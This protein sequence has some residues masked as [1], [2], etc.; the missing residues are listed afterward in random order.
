MAATA[1]IINQ[2]RV[3]R[4]NLHELIFKDDADAYD[5]LTIACAWAIFWALFFPIGKPLLWKATYGK[6]WLRKGITKEVQRAG[7]WKAMNEAMGTD[8]TN[9][10]ELIAHMMWN[11][12]DFQIGTF[13]HMIGGVLCIPSLLGIGDSNWSSSLAVLGILSEVGWEI[14]HMV[15]DVFYPRIRYG[16]E[17]VPMIVIIGSLIHHSLATGLGI[18]LILRYRQWQILHALSFDLQFGPTLVAPL[19][20]YGKLLDVAN[21]SELCRFKIINLLKVI[22]VG[23]TRGINFVYLVVHA[24]I[25]WYNDKAWVF[26]I[27]GSPL[28]LAF[29]YFCCYFYVLGTVKTYLKFRNAT[30]EYENV[31]DDTSKSVKEKRDSKANLEDIARE[32]FEEDENIDPA[33]QLTVFIGNMQDGERQINRRKTMPPHLTRSLNTTSMRL[34]RRGVSAPAGEWKLD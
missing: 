1:A 6:G 30:A 25:R 18:P 23:W 2:L 13:Q 31:R 11:W 20:E 15:V 34:T 7:G 3:C 24:I 27:V 28:L 14:E 19:A 9:E 5:L 8:F 12:A 32:L 26:L 4:N 33:N 29:T 10:E 17:K 21:P 22:I 16:A